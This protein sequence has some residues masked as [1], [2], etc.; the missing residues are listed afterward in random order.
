[1]ATGPCRGCGDRGHGRGPRRRARRLGRPGER[2]AAA[3]RGHRR[4][5]GPRRRRRLGGR[6]LLGAVPGG[7]PVPAPCRPAPGGDT[8]RCGRG[9]SGQRPGPRCTRLVRHQPHVARPPRP[10]GPPP[11]GPRGG[12]QEVRAGPPGRAQPRGFDRRVHRHPPHHAVGRV[13]HPRSRR[14]PAGRRADRHAAGGA[15]GRPEVRPTAVPRLADP[16]DGGADAGVRPAPRRCGEPR[17]RGAAAGCPVCST[18]RRR[19]S[20]CWSWSVASP[21]SSPPW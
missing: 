1:M 11:G 4:S 14:Q 20:R 9:G 15:D 19:P 7:R 3:G 6:P 13:D 12:P 18:A 10:P 2:P 8:G 5:A 16:G 21:P 17:R